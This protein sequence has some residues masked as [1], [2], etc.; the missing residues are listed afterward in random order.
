M[1]R[2]GRSCL[3]AM[4]TNANGVAST[5]TWSWTTSSLGA[6]VAAI[7]RTISSVFASHATIANQTTR[8]VDVTTLEAQKMLATVFQKMLG[9]SHMRMFTYEA[10]SNRMA[11]EFCVEHLTAFCDVFRGPCPCGQPLCPTRLELAIITCMRSQPSMGRIS[12]T[13]H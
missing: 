2:Y 8:T 4:V 12:G 6:T 9:E 11:K 3:R 5:W 7:T 1:Q 10:M 13:V